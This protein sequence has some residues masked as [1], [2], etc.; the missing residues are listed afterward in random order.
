MPDKNINSPKKIQSQSWINPHVELRSS[1]IHGRGIFAT[2]DIRQGEKVIVWG[3]VFFTHEDILAGRAVEHS[4][5]T[6]R[7]GVYLGHSLEQ[8]N[9]I[10]DFMNH[11]C[12]PNM[13]IIDDTTWIA[14]RDIRVGE[15][16][17]GDCATY[18]G[19]EHHEVYKWECH[20]GSA[21]CRKELS[22]LDW[23][24]ADLQERY[25]DHFTTFINEHIK[26]LH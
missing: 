16:L 14:R 3:G 9:S 4:Y 8:G 21:L 13:W 11:S 22:S 10:D 18:W 26:Q 2:A 15:E 23:Q 12:D 5:T 25:G 7:E 19:P 17:T 20:C 24:R 6:F 1:S